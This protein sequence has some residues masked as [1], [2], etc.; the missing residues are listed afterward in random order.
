[1]VLPHSPII[2]LLMSRE[3]MNRPLFLEEE[4]EKE[5]AKDDKLANEEIPFMS[6]KD[7]V[8]KVETGVI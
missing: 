5:K 1:M 4:E 6:H 7:S 3:W 8:V 2:G